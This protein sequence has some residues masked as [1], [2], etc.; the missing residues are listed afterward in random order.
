MSTAGMWKRLRPLAQPVTYLGVAMLVSI[1]SALAYLIVDD[2]RGA[3]QEAERQ[4]SDLVRI[5]EKSYSHVFKSL[6]FSL[7]FLR[8]SYELNAS[9]FR[10]SDWMHDPTIRNALSFDFIM[11]GADGRVTD[12]TFSRSIIGADRSQFESFRVHVESTTDEL[13]IGKPFRLLTT[14]RWAIAITRRLTAADGSFSGIIGA[15]LDPAELAKSLGAIDVGQGGQ[16]ALLGLD[17]VVRTRVL[18]GEVD[19]KSIGL[20]FPPRSMAVEYA[21]QS[22]LGHFWNV[23]GVIDRDRRLVSY[24]LLD[25]FPL[26][27]LTS[28]SEAQVYRYA[29]DHARI[30]WVAVLLLTAGIMV[31]IGMGAMHERRLIAATAQMTQAKEA[32]ARTNQDL[33]ARVAERTGELAQ[34]VRW[35]ED[36]QMRLARTNQDLETRVAARTAELAQE[37]RRREQAQMTLIQA[38]KMEAVGQLTAGIAHD[39]NNLLAVIR[40]SLGFVER[41]ATRG[42]AAEPELIEAALR[43]TR[44]GRDLVQRLLAFSRQTPLRTEPTTVD[45]LVMDTL[46]L[47]QRTL[48]VAI[49]IVTQ[50]DAPGA[51]VLVDRSQLANVLLNLALNARDAM[52]DGGQLTIATAC[53]P[54]RAVGAQGVI[55]SPTGEEV[56]ITIIDTGVGM[57]DDVRNRAFE[58]FFTTKEEGLGSGLGLSMVLGFV[59][60]SG[61]LIEIDS[62]VGRGTTIVIHLPR[63]EAVSQMGESN[64]VDELS[65]IKRNRTVLLVEDDPDVRIVMTAQLKQLGYAVHAVANG[66]E[67]I[68]LIES[69][70]T[71]DITLTDIV[72]PGGLDGVALVKEVM[73]ARPKMGVLCMSG[74]SPTQKHR[75]WLMVQNIT[76][77]EKPFSNARLAQALEA[78]LPE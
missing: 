68:D 61:G 38:Q 72:L 3:Y 9:T 19:W 15:F 58:P 4:G 8:K 53:R 52:P 67:A 48:G 75:K 31:A 24:R 56:C 45:Q 6:D 44:R 13:Y 1:Y 30:Y 22:K 55:R 18:N 78:V 23:P 28:I 21:Q 29:D 20:Q 59:Q 5:F 73:R 27:A 34:E 41:A 77:L 10:L 16:F 12:S 69:P 7:L 71:I 70:A 57:P 25:A 51:M 76:L 63:I 49:D 11:M 26:I 42:V 14:G 36:A 64:A 17:G 62:A 50:L 60:Q 32:L 66:V 54:V 37:M 43:A 35:R 40:G 65:A 74:Y 2:R 47:L 46:R 39:F 33:E